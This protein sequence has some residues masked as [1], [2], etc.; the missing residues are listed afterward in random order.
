MGFL[1]GFLWFLWVNTE[2]VTKEREDL[3]INHGAL[4]VWSM[5]I[6]DLI[7]SFHLSL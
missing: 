5:K 4:G 6:Q 2:W 3:E 1:T 7:G